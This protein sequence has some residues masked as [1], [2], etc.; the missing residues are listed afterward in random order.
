MLL[1]VSGIVRRQKLLN[2]PVERQCEACGRK[3]T[4]RK[5]SRKHK[6]A[7]SKVESTRKEAAAVPAAQ[8]APKAK[9]IKPA[10]TLTPHAPPAPSNSTSRPAVTEGLPDPLA[11]FPKLRALMN[12]SNAEAAAEVERV[13]LCFDRMEG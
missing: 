11:A 1:S 5:T 4:S 6:C 3:F 10:A 9:P 12:Q 7:K 8:V 2:S 13:R